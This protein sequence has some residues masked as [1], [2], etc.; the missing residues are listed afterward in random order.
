TVGDARDKRESPLRSRRMRNWRTARAAARARSLRGQDST[1]ANE[2]EG[3][4]SAAQKSEGSLMMR[5]F[6]AATRHKRT[7]PVS[8]VVP[9]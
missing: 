5:R 6:H 7:L 1:R 3:A 2:G 8:A 4:K 9:E